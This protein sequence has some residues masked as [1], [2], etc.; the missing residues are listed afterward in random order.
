M[1]NI[2]KR[3][4]IVK[5]RRL[6]G[7]SVSEIASVQGV[8]RRTVERIWKAYLIKGEQGI[9]PREVGRPK[10]PIPNHI[11]EL[12]INTKKETGFGVR[13]IEGILDLRG[14]HVPHN[15]IHEILSKAGL[16]EHNP[17]KGKRY[18]YIRWERKHSNSLWQTDFCWISKLDCWLCAWL[19]D[20]SRFITT[21]EYLTEATTNEVLRLI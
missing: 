8:S 21:A 1:L 16:I 20:H 11:K 9:I 2:K 13:K 4:W 19:D 17:K 15:K 5:Q 6:G 3:L 18:S 12:V 7:L 14:I 10:Q